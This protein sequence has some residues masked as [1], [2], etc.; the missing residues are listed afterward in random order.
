MIELPRSIVIDQ[1]VVPVD[2]VVGIVE[3]FK[4]VWATVV[5][6]GGAASASVAFGSPLSASS[7]LSTRSRGWRWGSGFSSSL[8]PS[9][10]TLIPLSLDLGGNRRNRRSGEDGVG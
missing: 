1:V 9:T 2:V 6:G 8:I 10:T 5:M 3:P 4:R 7:Y